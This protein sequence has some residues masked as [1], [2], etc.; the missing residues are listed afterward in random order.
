MVGSIRDWKALF[1]EVLGHPKPGGRIEV[2]D[3]RTRFECL[4]GTFEER[5]KACKEWA[6]AFHEIT[7]GM[8]MDFDPTPSIP[9][10]VVVLG[11]SVVT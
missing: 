4:D 5:G 6:D 1:A 10:S 8:W 3:I 7:K 9:V 11:V 2:T